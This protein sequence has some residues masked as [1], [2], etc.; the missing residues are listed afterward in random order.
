MS[1]ITI[2]ASQIDGFQ[3]NGIGAD[4][5]LS[6]ITVT[7]GL[8]SVT[9]TN[10]LPQSVVGLGGFKI[11]FSTGITYTVE[12]VTSRSALTLT[13]NYAESSGTVTATLHKMVHLRVYVLTAFTPS[14]ETYVAQPGSPGSTAW[15]RRYGV[16]IINDGSQNVAHIPE[17]VLPA[18]TNSN[19]PTAR[20]FAGLYTQGGGFV[21][22][23]PGCVDQ[24]QLDHLTTPTSW[25]GICNFNIPPPPTP[26]LSTDDFVTES[27]LNARL[28][29]G[30]ANQLLYFENTGN[31]LT[32]LTLSAEFS[33][34][35]DTLS[36]AAPATGY[37]RVQEEGANLPQR[38]TLNFIGSAFTAAD[39]VGNTR[40][41]VSADSDLNAIASNS[42]N[43]IYARTGAGTVSARTITGTA[44]EITSTNGDGVAGNP[45]LSLPAALT[46]TG[47]TVTGGTFATPTITTPTITGGTHTAIT[48]LGVRLTG[49][50][51][52]DLTIANTENLAAGRT[53][54][55]TVND[56]ARTLS[57]AGNLTTGGAFTTSST[58]SIT[59][60]FT[61]AAAFTTAGANA[62]TLTTTG[63]TNVTL[64]TTGTLATLAGSETFTNKTLTSPRIGASILD[65]NGNELFL[66]TA[67]GSAVNEVTY[68]NA[69]TTGAPS[70]TASGGDSN[71]NLNLRAKGTGRVSIL[72]YP[73]TLEVN[74][75]PVANVGAGLDNLQAYVLPANELATNG[76]RLLV[77][78]AGTMADTAVSKRLFV[79][80]GGQTAMDT[81]SLSLGGGAGSDQLQWQVDI[82][83]TRLTST[84]I[85]CA[86][87]VRIGQIIIDNAGVLS[88]AGSNAVYLNRNLTVTVANLASNTTTLLVAAEG[89]N[90]NDIIQTLSTVQLIQR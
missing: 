90:N 79:S 17:I 58:V 77:S 6:G 68:A 28:P 26:N 38:A 22:A 37:N 3:P 62:L 69:A 70:F 4:L 7:L 14:G 43:G 36:L 46:F 66:L 35:A 40:T 81:G 27:E 50:G 65:T 23:Y 29:S 52:F 41:D 47:K 15:F 78:Y 63:S 20:Y 82:I 86:V 25:A 73:Y 21:Q 56:A 61:T 1:D 32:P 53:L 76:D 57:L 74:T 9:G 2:G 54:T 60:A 34:A 18:T 39:D 5:A 12:T 30:V 42:T 13:T 31:V 71:I 88:A 89:T 24:W 80:I 83:Y 48:G 85:L 87:S 59:G 72:G 16:S 8:D 10:F 51:A 75:T 11:T 33:I 19:V 45:T 67:T 55:I 49:S 84:T 64:P 44:N